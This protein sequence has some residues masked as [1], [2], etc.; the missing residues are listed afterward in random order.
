M[1][2]LAAVAFVL[3]SSLVLLVAVRGLG[4]L[5]RTPIITYRSPNVTLENYD[6]SR[7]MSAPLLRGIE[8]LPVAWTWSPDGRRLAYVLLGYSTG[9]YEIRL[10]SPELR[11][12]SP[13]AKGLPWGAP[14][15]WSPDGRTI[16]AINENQDVCLYP[17]DGGLVRCLNVLPAIL[18][19]WSPDGTSIAYL[20]RIPEGGLHRVDVESGAVMPVFTGVNGVNAQRWSPDGSRLVFTYQPTPSG[21]R[22]IYV[23]SSD[24]SEARALVDDQTINYEPTWSPDGRFVAFSTHPE[25]EPRLMSAAVVDVETGDIVFSTAYRM[26]ETDP[27]W[28]PDGR[29]FTFV[30]DSMDRSPPALHVFRS[31]ARTFDTPLASIPINLYAYAWRP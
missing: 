23:A 24:G 17:V 8:N 22:H 5:F 27:Q 9:G 21:L 11:Q 14:P 1:R 6:L 20:S 28:S 18:P 19:V 26:V 2:R 3:L 4:G 15:Q 12:S 10:W 7:G 31:D 16:A 30:F 25:G 13:I 29:Y